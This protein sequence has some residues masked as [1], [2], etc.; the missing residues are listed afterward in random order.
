LSA[1]A[2]PS[3]APDASHASD[4]DA[5]LQLARLQFNVFGRTGLKIIVLFDL[6]LQQHELVAM[7]RNVSDQVLKDGL[8]QLPIAAG[9][10]QADPEKIGDEVAEVDEAVMNPPDQPAST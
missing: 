6:F 9:R 10:I 1:S 8:F 7:F 2:Q 3:L 5:R 4:F